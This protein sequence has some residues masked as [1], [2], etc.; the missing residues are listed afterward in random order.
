MV[1]YLAKFMPHLSQITA[2]PTSGG[3]ECELP[4]IRTALPC[5]EH[6]H[7]FP[8]LRY[9]GVNMPVTVQCDASRSSLEAVLLQEGQ[10]VCYAFSALTDTVSICPDRNEMLA[11]TWA[12]DQFDQNLYGRETVIFETDNEPLESAFK[13]EVHKSLKRLQ[14]MRLALQKYNLE[15]QYKKGPLMYIADALSRAHLKTTQGVQTGFCEIRA[16][17]EHIQVEPS[18]RNELRQRLAEDADIQ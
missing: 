4:G 18:E 2:T 5:N 14:R 7:E 13:T 10:P 17:E 12:C 3:Q 16:F 1:T 6:D 9:Y 11:I 15:V 8:G